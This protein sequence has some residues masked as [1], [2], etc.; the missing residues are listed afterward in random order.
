MA[1]MLILAACSSPE[2]KKSAAVNEKLNGFSK[3]TYGYDLEFLKKNNVETLELRDSISGASVLLAPRYQGRVMTSSASGEKGYSF[4]WINYD[5]VASGKVLE[6]FNPVGG[7]ERFWLGPEGGPFSIYFAPGK[8][9]VYD[10]W[11]VPPLLD[12][13]EFEVAKQGTGFVK[14]VRKANLTN[15]SGF[16]F[17]LGIERTVTL[18]TPDI[19]GS[20]FGI[21][22]PEELNIVAYQ[23]ENTLMN[24]GEVPWTK[25][26]GLLSIWLLSMLNPSP[27]T[28]VF[29]PFN[30]DAGG[31]IVNDD[32]FG[33]VP[34][35]RLLVEDS[36]IYFKIDGEFRSK[37]GI[38][39]GRAGELCGSYDPGNQTLTL[40]WCSVTDQGKVY[41]NSR[42]GE[43]DD[44]YSG[45]VIN[46]Y[47]DGPLADGSIMGPFYEIETSSP[48]AE[49]E[50][51]ASL[52]HVQR[53]VHFQGE[54]KQL[55]TIV[56]D[57]FGLSLKDIVN[58][59]RQ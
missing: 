1:A 59:F 11:V 12:T 49:L 35:N 5:L 50:P 18:L 19:T 48:A 56:A 33:K 53:I 6:Q 45:D 2:S 57:L 42:W 54:E 43:Q 4:G 38:P 23:T 15:A 36:V 39:P 30:K 51:G 17:H 31:K 20:L 32:Y 44:P 52:T 22:I 9:Q 16:N 25:E 40:L 34:A 26:S 21:D 28:T 8:E 14:F 29:I 3:G 46:S 27:G 55:E 37:I 10:N 7:E 24:T 47:N 58:K 41:V 13:E